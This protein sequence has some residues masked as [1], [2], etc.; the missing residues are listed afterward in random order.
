[1]SIERLKQLQESMAVKHAFKPGD[2]VVWKR[3][4]KNKKIPRDG[5]QVVVV[6]VLEQPVPDREEISAGSQYFNEPLDLQLGVFDSDG[7]FAVY[8]FDSRRFEP[9]G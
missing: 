5:D 9:A 4:L 6:A 2:A 3:G 7:D 1:M 8:H